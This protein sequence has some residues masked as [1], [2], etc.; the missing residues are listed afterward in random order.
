VFGGVGDPQPIRLVAGELAVDQIGGDRALRL[1]PGPFGAG[2]AL[3][4]GAAHQHL[5]SVVPDADSAAEREFS[6]HSAGAVGAARVEMDSA[7]QFGQ[8]DMPQLPR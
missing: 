5:H 1:D 4:S 7:D 2:Q 6:V 8:P 3:E